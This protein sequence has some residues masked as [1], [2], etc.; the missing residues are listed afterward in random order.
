MKFVKLLFKI[1]LSTGLLV[2]LVLSA[3]TNRIYELLNG[4]WNQGRLNYLLAATGLFVVSVGLFA[5]RWQVLLKS[6][7]YRPSLWSLFRYYMMGLFFNNFLPTAIGGDVVRI[8][9]VIQDTDDRN[10]GFASVM[11]ERLMGMV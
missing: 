2:Y 3:D 6:Y 11:T 1:L 8:Y 7:G 5:Y 9:K 4:I 10:V